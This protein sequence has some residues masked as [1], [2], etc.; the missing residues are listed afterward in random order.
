MSQ[1]HP[2]HRK[3]PTESEPIAAGPLDVSSERPTV[4]WLVRHAEVEAAYQGVFGGR[5][6][7]ELS[8]RGRRQAEALAAYLRRTTFDALYASPMK[9]VEQTLAPTL[10]DGM[11]RPVVVPELREVD[12]GDWTGLKWEEVQGQFGVSAFTWL[13]QLECGGIANAESSQTLRA[14]LEPCLSQILKQHPGQQVLLACH[15]GVIRMLL[16]ML[17]QWPLP[18]MGALEVE[19]AS[20]TRVVMLARRPQLQLL[21]FTPWREG[22]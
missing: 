9:R 11:P 19:Y 6:D 13:D 7:M 4:L 5:I 8:P 1:I 15:G 16:A 21:N 14:R 18:T 10:F 20:V 3:S 12:F 22:L 17:L 2:S